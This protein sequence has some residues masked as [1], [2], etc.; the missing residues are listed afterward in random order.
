MD[1][2]PK[3]LYRAPGTEHVHGMLLS[4]R[5]V[6]DADEEA[7]ALADGW[8]TTTPEA[9]AAHEATLAAESAATADT[10]APD[11]EQPV[12]L[13]AQAEALGLKVDRRWGPA[14][15]ADEIAKAR[16]AAQG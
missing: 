14:R 8:H 5:I 15:L 6:A 3:M 2:F 16:A 4:T 1:D 9:K 12:D 13:K 11:P 7:A 10:S